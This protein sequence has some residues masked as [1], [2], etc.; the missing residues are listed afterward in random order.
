VPFLDSITWFNYFTLTLEHIPSPIMTGHSQVWCLLCSRER[1]DSIRIVFT[2]A[3]KEYVE[4]GCAID[5]VSAISRVVVFSL[6]FNTIARTKLGRKCASS[7]SV[8]L[9]VNVA[10]MSSVSSTNYSNLESIA[11]FRYRTN[12]TACFLLSR[13]MLYHERL[14]IYQLGL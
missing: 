2:A 12:D 9:H 4:C 10:A 11:S 1:F 14:G 7:Y 8:L 6:L 3:S 13:Y 5:T